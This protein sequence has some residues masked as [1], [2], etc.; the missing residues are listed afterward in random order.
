MRLKLFFLSIKTRILLSNMFTKD[1]SFFQSSVLPLDLMLSKG[2]VDLVKLFSLVYVGNN[3]FETFYSLLQLGE[4]KAL[5]KKKHYLFAKYFD[6]SFFTGFISKR[7]VLSVLIPIKYFYHRLRHLGFLHFYK[8]RPIGNIRYLNYS[9][10]LI[11]KWYGY[12]AFSFLYWFR[13][14]NNFSYVKVF[15]ELLR[16][17]CLLTLARKHNKTKVWVYS[18]YTSNL[19]ILKV[20]NNLSCVRRW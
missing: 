11:V 15:L 20:F 1:I 12:L 18:V 7:F 4:I 6:N 16:N 9:D 13:G 14:V 5:S 3:F 19:I 10:S 17:S 2:L 8:F